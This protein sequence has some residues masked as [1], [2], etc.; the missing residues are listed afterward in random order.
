MKAFQIDFRCTNCG[1]QW[2]EQ[3]DSGD[4]V[5]DGWGGIRLHSA[6]CTGD[7]ACKKCRTIACPVC[8]LE[9]SVCVAERRPIGAVL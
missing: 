3:F 4:E 6:K 2:N 5:R 8:Q 1:H 9:K 7:F